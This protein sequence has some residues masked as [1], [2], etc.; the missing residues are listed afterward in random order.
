MKVFPKGG[1]PASG[2]P[3]EDLSCL[4]GLGGPG[5]SSVVSDQQPVVGRRFPSACKRQSPLRPDQ[6][7]AGPELW[8][9]HLP[10]GQRALKLGLAA[11]WRLFYGQYFCI[12]KIM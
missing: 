12:W 5:P 8:V 11:G 4:A 7:E 10:P 3:G 9:L 6:L 1:V 2:G